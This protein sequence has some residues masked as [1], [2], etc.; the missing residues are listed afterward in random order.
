M[1]TLTDTH[2]HTHTCTHC[3]LCSHCRPTRV[4]SEKKMGN[5]PSAINTHAC[6]TVA[7]PPTPPSNTSIAPH[8]NSPHPFR[9]LCLPLRP[10]IYSLP[11]SIEFSRMFMR[12]YKATVGQKAF[13]MQRSSWKFSH[14]LIVCF[15]LKIYW[16]YSVTS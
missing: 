8:P 15:S 9:P 6:F 16:E 5:F 4:E 14:F 10:A 11:E 12:R 3:E 7:A 13:Q 2:S 1:H